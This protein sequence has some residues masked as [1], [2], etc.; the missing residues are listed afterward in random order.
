MCVFVN[1]KW[2]A[3]T[4][5]NVIFC[6]KILFCRLVSRLSR[7]V[8]LHQ[9]MMVKAALSLQVRRYID[10]RKYLKNQTDL[11]LLHVAFA[12]YVYYYWT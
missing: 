8:L 7:V 3:M 11:Q 9:L 12:R 10:M 4:Y 1:Q 6:F 5:R 2:E